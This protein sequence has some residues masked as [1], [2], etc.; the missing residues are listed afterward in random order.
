MRET[1]ERLQREVRLLRTYVIASTTVLSAIALMAF[2]QSS[3]AP[4]RFDEIDVQ[5]INI[6]EA[7]G[8]LR[9]VFSNRARSSGPVMRGKPFGYAGGNR[10]GI[11]FFNDEETENGGLVF[12]G[13]ADSTG[14]YAA[15][16]QLSFDQ[17]DQDQVVTLA[18]EDENGKRSMGF[19]VTD[20]PV[21]PFNHV[22]TMDSISRLPDGP[23]K[24]AAL[25]RMFSPVRGMPMFAPRVFVGRDTARAA[26]LRLSDPSG[27]PRLRMTV[28]SLG[29]ARIEFLDARG[30]VTQQI[31][32]TLAQDT[33]RNPLRELMR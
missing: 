4:T 28:D 24:F 9:M 11:I 7:D 8:K 21:L 3:A 19:N 5:R 15:G 17:Y 20:R 13:K 25:R 14:R 33:S 30:K 10:P 32:P 23:E 27:R 29:V 18:Y 16:A 1:H 6:R 26:V 31:P 22:A 12:E 2:R